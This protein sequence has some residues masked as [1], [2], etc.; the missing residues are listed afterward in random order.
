M[1]NVTLIPVYK[2]N[3]SFLLEAEDGST[4]VVDPG[5]AEAVIDYCEDHGLKLDYV[6]NTHHHWDH[7]DGNAALIK[8]YGAKLAAPAAETD[9][10]S[11]IDIP[12]SE[13]ENFSFGGEIVQILETPGHTRGH[14]C[15]Y[16][17]ESKKVFTGD[18]LF[19]M[20][21]GRLF[22]GTPEQAWNSLNKLMAL[23]GETEVYCGHE[24][25]LASAKFCM[26][27]EPDNED[28]KARYKAM[29]ELRRKKRPTVPG[30]IEDELK[31]NVFLRAG[32][33]ENFAHIRRLKDNA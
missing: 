14:I 11:G 8:Q 19:L 16:F 24:Y 6:I 15:L 18:T 17:P 5:E 29:K 22:E 9:R 21:C 23:P 30:T 3:Y 32:S 2:D 13:A 1:I 12:L 7:V 4:A 20:G 25:T 27:I 31:T 28:L 33:A 26:S 10:I